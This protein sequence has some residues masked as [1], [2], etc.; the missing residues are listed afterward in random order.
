MFCD[1]KAKTNFSENFQDYGVHLEHQVILSDFFYTALPKVIQTQGW[2]SLCG[3]LKRCLVVFI[4]EFYSNM[5]A[6]DTSKA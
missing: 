5:H 2:E 3:K 4:Q 1:E 6:I